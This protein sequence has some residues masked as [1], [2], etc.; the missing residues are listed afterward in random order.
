MIKL[1]NAC[2][3]AFVEGGAAEIYV[4]DPTVQDISDD[5][6]AQRGDNA[7]NYELEMEQTS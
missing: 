5:E 3:I 2:L 7:S 6:D 1:V 4:E